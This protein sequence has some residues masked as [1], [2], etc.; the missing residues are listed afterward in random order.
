MVIRALLACIA[1]MA[2]F[3]ARSAELPD[4]IDQS[5]PSVVLVGTYAETDSPRFMFR[6][7][8]FV[9]GNGN[10]A[11]TN[12]H[13]IPAVMTNEVG[14]RLI[15]QVRRTSGEWA[16]RSATVSAL[17]KTHDLALLRFDGP[18]AAALPLR[19]GTVREG[20]GV[21]LM[22]FP[23][24]GA[25]GFSTVTHRGIVSAVTGIALPTPNAQ[26]LNASAVLRLRDGG[27][28]I[29]QLDATAYPGNSGG[30]VL[31]AQVGDVVGVVNMVV[32]KRSRESALTDPSGITYA[33]PAS[34]AAA[35]VD[36]ELGGKP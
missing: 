36:Q 31:D 4:L 9:V 27:F 5:K 19:K 35:L 21:A 26:S 7:T 10:L 29:L 17:D 30:P 25:L 2:A 12:A 18:A 34:F 8:G 28:D 6:G 1:L 16:A 15:I 11:I 32:V 20:T 23:L 33:I 3:D 24:G 14:R 13:V 22:G